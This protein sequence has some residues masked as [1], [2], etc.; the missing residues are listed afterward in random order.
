MGAGN[1]LGTQL[2]TLRVAVSGANDG[3]SIR[4][5]VLDS[6]TPESHT[7]SPF[8]KGLV[9]F[10]ALGRPYAIG[11]SADF[12]IVPKWRKVVRQIG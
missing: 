7:R 2:T 6:G 4:L 5:S 12:P 8:Y 3:T 10:D 9:A 11:A 1:G